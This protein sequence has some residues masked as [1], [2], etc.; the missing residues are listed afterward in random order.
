MSFPSSLCVNEHVPPDDDFPALRLLRIEEVMEARALLRC[1]W[2]SFVAS[3]R[4]S[5]DRDALE[6][7]L[8]PTAAC[9]DQRSYFHMFPPILFGSRLSPAA[10]S[11]PS[12]S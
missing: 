9:D 6:V 12:Q 11:R 4:D 10:V 8:R 1:A 2:R 3:V 5:A 7:S